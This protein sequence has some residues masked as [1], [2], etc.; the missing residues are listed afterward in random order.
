[1]NELQFK[2]E[3][4]KGEILHPSL[5]IKSR[6][7]IYGFSYITKE[8]QRENLFLIYKDSKCEL[9]KNDSFKFDSKSYYVDI[10]GRRL[11]DI[12]EKWG[13]ENLRKFVDDYNSGKSGIYIGNKELFNKL[14]ELLKKYGELR[15]EIDYSLVSAL[16]IGTYVFPIFPK[17]PFLYF[18]GVKGS[19]K[20]QILTFLKQVC[21]NAHKERPSMPALVDIVDSLRGTYLIDQADYLKR[22]GYEDLVDILADSYRKGGGKRAFIRFDEYKRR[23]ISEPDAYSPKVFAS[24]YDPPED[25]SDRCLLI[26]L[27]KSR[28][29]FPEPD[30]ENEDW[31]EIRGELY[32]FGIINYSTIKSHYEILSV[33]YRADPKITGRELDIWLPIEVILKVCSPE[34]IDEAKKRFKQL[35]GYTGYEATDLEKEIIKIISDSFPPD[36]NQIT[37]SPKEINEEIREELWMSSNLPPRAKETIIG[38][39]ITKFNLSTEKKHAFQGTVYLF[40]KGNVLD[41]RDQYIG[42]SGG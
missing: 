26:P 21:F 37:L 15:K 36:K 12:E 22:K 30:D 23:S 28:R 4:F 2:L 33:Q 34:E 1:M 7:L 31:K 32:K 6:I 25:L 40:E 35:Y 17:Y 3:P 19:G 8:R 42:K 29:N 41:I 24:I 20:S 13:F 39:I 18:K 5:D 11:A 27:I 10:K 9:I 38:R 16:N 14:K